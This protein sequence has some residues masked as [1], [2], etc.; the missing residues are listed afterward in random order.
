MRRKKS[1][2]NLSP[3]SWER[4][5]FWR[6]GHIVDVEVWQG[7]RLLLQTP[8][9]LSPLAVEVDYCDVHRTRIYADLACQHCGMRPTAEPKAASNRRLIA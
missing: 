1:I 3:R 7:N 2:V 9:K 6:D 4:R 5:R 8:R